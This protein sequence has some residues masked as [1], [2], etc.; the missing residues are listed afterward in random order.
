MNYNYLVRNKKVA[1]LVLIST[2]LIAG[3]S[4]KSA[5]LDP[6]EL[7]KRYGLQEAFADSISTPEGSIKATI[8]PVTLTDGRTAQLV[9]PQKREDYPLY[10]RDDSGMHPVVLGDRNVGRDQFVRSEPK[11]VDRKPVPEPTR[12]RSWQKEALIIG[13]SAGAGAGIGAIAGGKKG[14]AI[15]AAS[16]GVA[17]LIYDIA[18][19]DKDNKK[20]GS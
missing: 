11:I 8:V 15:G 10:L 17:G 13:G 16:G 5:G 3:C 4:R 9:I 6:E 1:A 20:K 2:L 7:Q 19:R 14:A 18:T 12:K